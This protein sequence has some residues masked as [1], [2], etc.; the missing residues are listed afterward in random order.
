MAGSYSL[1][2]NFYKLLVSTVNS[3]E[4][5]KEK[6]NGSY[7]IYWIISNHHC[8]QAKKLVEQHLIFIKPFIT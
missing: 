1:K 5:V 8:K 6:E 4:M 7:T 3:T 2:F